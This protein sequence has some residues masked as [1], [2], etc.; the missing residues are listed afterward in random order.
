MFNFYQFVF[1]IISF[2]IGKFDGFESRKRNY[3]ILR[4]KVE[5]LGGSG[6]MGG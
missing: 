4:F 5:N 1:K 3:G 6:G 2:S